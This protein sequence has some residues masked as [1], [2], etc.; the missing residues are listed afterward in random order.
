LVWIRH[1]GRPARWDGRA[2]RQRHRGHLFGTAPTPCWQLAVVNSMVSPF[3]SIATAFP[4][5]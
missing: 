3:R 2:T 5:N 4:R 1:R